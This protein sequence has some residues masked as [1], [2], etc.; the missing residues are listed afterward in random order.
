[1]GVA[2]R[3]LRPPLRSFA[4]EL[5]S[6]AVALSSASLLPARGCD[7][8]L[9]RYPPLLTDRLLLG[10]HL[11]SCLLGCDRLLLCSHLLLCCTCAGLRSLA[12]CAVC[13]QRP[14]GAA[15][16]LLLFC[17]GAS[18]ICWLRVAS[19]I[20]CTARSACCRFSGSGR[21]LCT[22]PS[23][24]REAP[25]AS[26]VLRSATIVHTLPSSS[27]KPHNLVLQEAPAAL[28]TRCALQTNQASWVEHQSYL[29]P[30]SLLPN[31]E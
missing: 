13:Q 25:L 6:L 4:A 29:N 2:F 20:C 11:I 10:Y 21:S 30:I 19:C 24:L 31:A 9:L 18:C 27:K 17:D 5:R 22:A 8:S 1:M 26:L 7:S 12:V 3:C 28:V 15:M 23:L 14:A 16:K